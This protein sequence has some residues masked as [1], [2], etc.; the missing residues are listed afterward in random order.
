MCLFLHVSVFMMALSRA[1]RCSATEVYCFVLFLLSLGVSL[2][3]IARI[4]GGHLMF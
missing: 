3:H 2:C 1:T 4:M